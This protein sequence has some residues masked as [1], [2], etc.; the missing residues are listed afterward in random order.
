MKRILTGGA[1]LR[2]EERLQQREDRLSTKN[3]DLKAENERLR[4]EI[5]RLRKAI[6]DEDG[7]MEIRRLRMQLIDIYR[8]RN[9]AIAEVDRLREAKPGMVWVKHDGSKVCP[10]NQNW[11]VAVFRRGE[12][13][14][15][16]ARLV[17]W[18]NVTHYAII[19]QPEKK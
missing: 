10:V 19:T 9:L 14:A 12:A 5:E 6:T 2:R 1:A 8:E 18:P 16:R 15:A 13:D 3:A 7:E 4:A 17:D 11:F